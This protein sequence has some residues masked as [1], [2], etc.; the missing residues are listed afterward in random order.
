MLILKL[1]Q[2]TPSRRKTEAN[3]IAAEDVKH[4]LAIA[5]TLAKASLLFLHTAAFTGALA[6]LLLLTHTLPCAIIWRLAKAPIRKG[7]SEK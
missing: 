5:P 1:N 3:G 2:P 4:L 6:V 7:S